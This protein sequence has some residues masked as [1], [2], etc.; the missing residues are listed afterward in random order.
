MSEKLILRNVVEGCDEYE[1]DLSKRIYMFSSLREYN[2]CNFVI[3]KLESIRRVTSRFLVNDPKNGEDLNYLGDKEFIYVNGDDTITLNKNGRFIK[4]NGEDISDYFNGPDLNG[5][6]PCKVKYSGGSGGGGIE[7]SYLYLRNIDSMKAPYEQM[8]Q[9]DII[10]K[11]VTD[12]PSCKVFFS[13]VSP[14]VVNYF[15]VNLLRHYEELNDKFSYYQICNEADGETGKFTIWR[16]N[17]VC[18]KSGRKFADTLDFSDIMEVIYDE[19]C[20]EK[21][22]YNRRNNIEQ[23]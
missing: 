13:T 21:E 16:L 8:D 17:A 14:Y 9:L 22:M 19:Y 7:N 3:D 6:G 15:N 10:F 23:K 1:I 18:N 20:Y 12:N 11:I 4:R 5:W 2:L